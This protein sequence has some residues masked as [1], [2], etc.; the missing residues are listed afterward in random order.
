MSFERASY[1]DIFADEQIVFKSKSTFHPRRILV[2]GAQGMIGNA[3]ACSLQHLQQLGILR[4]TELVLASRNWEKDYIKK[5][6]TASGLRFINNSEITAIG[7]I[8]LVIH[9]ASP[10]NITRIQSLHQLRE[11]NGGFISLV[12]KLKPERIVYLSSGEVYKGEDLAEGDRS[13]NFSEQERRDWYPIAKLEA[14]DT[15]KSLATTG[16]LNAQV[17]RLF[18][19]FGPGVKSDDGR[20]FA[21]ILWGAVANG[22]ITLRSQG[23]QIRTFL[24][25]GDAARGIVSASLFA[26]KE[27]E[28]FNLGSDT[29]ISILEFA[30]IT[31]RITNSKIMFI[32][33][34]DFLHSPN[35]HIVPKMGNIK[36]CGWGPQ[37]DLET[38]IRRTAN[39]I[40]NSIPKLK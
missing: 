32:N 7:K 6:S 18:H 29:P 33:N 17:I 16:E 14:E 3:V 38:G 40:Q 2:T 11:V 31:A 20:S 23:G 27:F 19:T 24:Y 9:A 5:Y 30:Q 10:S 21:D 37:I 36:S 8:D 12:R 26:S 15:L 35:E 22:E 34:Q 4:A 25:L 1:K 39:W 28:I 13:G